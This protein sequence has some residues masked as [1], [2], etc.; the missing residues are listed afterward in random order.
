MLAH[1]SS[2]TAVIFLCLQM[3]FCYY[4][5]K[6]ILCLNYIHKINQQHF[7][8]RPLLPDPAVIYPR[9]Q[10]RPPAVQPFLI[11][12]ASIPLF[13]R[14]IVAEVKILSPVIQIPSAPKTDVRIAPCRKYAKLR[15]GSLRTLIALTFRPHLMKHANVAVFL[16]VEQFH[17]IHPLPPVVVIHYAAMCNLKQPVLKPHP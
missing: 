13:T 1:R 7:L 16:L 10:P 2:L 5:F 15:K 14:R 12:H 9:I 17:V 4:V 11:R 6:K 8:F 3:L